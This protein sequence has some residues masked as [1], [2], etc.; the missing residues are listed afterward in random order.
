[1]TTL[2]AAAVRTIASPAEHLYD[3]V[4]DFRTH[5]PHILPSN[6]GDFRVVSGGFG[7]GTETFSTM[8]LGGRTQ[9]LRTKVTRAEAPTLI[10]E[11]VL[12]RPMTTTFAFTQT[13]DGTAVRIET[14][15][16]P[17]TGFAGLLERWFAPRMLARVYADELRRLE[18]YAAF[19]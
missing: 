19:V 13:G 6:F 18:A 7:V 5:H 2:T 16:L 15:W 14:S 11:I 10:E 8:T 1:M 17:G 4:A 9:T 3:L 12:D